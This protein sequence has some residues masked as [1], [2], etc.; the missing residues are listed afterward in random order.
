MATA[1]RDDNDMNALVRRYS[2]QAKSDVLLYS[3]PIVYGPA[4]EFVDLLTRKQTK[5]ETVLFFLTTPGGDPHA[6]FRMIR[7]LQI[8]YKK[9]RLGVVGPCKS[10]GTLIS[11]G[12]HELVMSNSGELGPLDVQLSKPDEI[13]QN[14]S[15][16]DVIEALASVTDFAFDALEQRL[17]ELVEHSLGNIST[18]T[19]ADIATSFVVELF[20]PIMAQIE[21]NRFGEIQRAIKISVAYGERLGRP[22]LKSSGSLDKLVQGYPSHG[23]VIDAA[24]AAEI[25]KKVSRLTDDEAQIAT[26]HRSLLR[27]F[28]PTPTY[29][30]IGADA[31]KPATGA[32]NARRPDLPS[33]QDRRSV[34]SRTASRPPHRK[35]A[36]PRTSVN[37]SGGGRKGGVVRRL[38]PP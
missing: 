21:P 36:M 12:A 9:V 16:L 10:A 28:R 17:L 2:D 33:D 26:V 15:G 7:A 23:F 32:E 24:E 6:A 19:A 18:K 20:K 31:A 25:Y 8:K 34:P 27:H 38:P 11:V 13:I 5:N 1:P 4:C 3:G 22:N 14:S 37:G 29:L 35:G 30:D